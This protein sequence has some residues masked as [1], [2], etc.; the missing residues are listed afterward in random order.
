MPPEA[1]PVAPANR[2]TAIASEIRGFPFMLISRF[3]MVSKPGT[4]LTTVPN[5]TAALVLIIAVTDPTA[6]ALMA[7]TKDFTFWKFR[8]RMSKIPDSKATMMS[9]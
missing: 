1:D 6:P 8:I 9:H 2:L 4:A 3:V 5:P 7:L